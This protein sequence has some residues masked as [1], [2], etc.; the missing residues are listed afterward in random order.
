MRSFLLCGVM[1][2]AVAACSRPVG[3]LAAFGVARIGP[4]EMQVITADPLVIPP[5]LDLPEPTPGQRNRANPLPRSS[6]I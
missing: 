2:C 1:L 5:T 4:L 3:D 6:A